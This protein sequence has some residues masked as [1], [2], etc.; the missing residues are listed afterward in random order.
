MTGQGLEG[1]RVLVAGASSGIGRAC[2][3]QAV[4]HGARVA[5]VARRLDRLQEAVDEAG[6]GSAIAGD[7]R[8]PEQCRRIVDET[9]AALGGIDVVVFATGVAPL[10]RLE[11]TTADDW[12]DVFTTN[13]V[14]F[15]QLVRHA[16]PS[17]DRDGVVA[18][19]SS[20]S[21]PYPRSALAAYTA[22]KAALE[23]TVR[24][25][26]VEHA[27][28]RFMTVTVGATQ[29][30]SFGDDFDPVAVGEA[31]RDWQRRG[32]NQQ[33]FMETEEVAAVVVGA[34][35]LVCAN[36]SIGIEQLTV[37]SPSPVATN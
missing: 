13:V 4:A 36:R 22:S 11:D 14:G 12:N 26:R 17:L 32:I 37:R 20:E 9:I 34:I 2:G 15:H 10:R 35:A 25:W 7:V 3:R 29:P 16:L 21:V 23:M 33:E 27:P 1:R 18:A 31:W 8:E 24:G 28:L 19:L 5:F 6:G 30:T